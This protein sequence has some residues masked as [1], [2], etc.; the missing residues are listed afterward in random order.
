[1]RLLRWTLGGLVIG[2]LA[3][4]VWFLI[5]LI[6]PSNVPDDVDGGA[7]LNV[8]MLFIAAV[9]ATIG[10]VVVGLIGLLLRVSTKWQGAPCPG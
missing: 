6:V 2:A 7:G 1:M 5:I 3:G 8:V 4:S 10:G 9:F